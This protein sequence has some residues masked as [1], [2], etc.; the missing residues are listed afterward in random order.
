MADESTRDIAKNI[1]TELQTMMVYMYGR[2]IEEKEH[3][4]IEDYA[5]PLIPIISK[6]GAS[7]MKMNKRPFGFTY[8]LNGCVY[9]V[10]INSTNY[11]YCRKA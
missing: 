2:W 8:N 11:S 4:S 1:F 5:I 7:F 10:K 6:F 9:Q 3:E